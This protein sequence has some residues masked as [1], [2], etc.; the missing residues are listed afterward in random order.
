MMP[1]RWPLPRPQQRN[2]YR[3]VAPVEALSAR[4]FRL[5]IERGYS[6]NDL[7]IAAG[8][9]AGTIKTGQSV[10]VVSGPNGIPHK[11]RV[12]QLHRFAG[13]GRAGAE[14]PPPT[15]TVELVNNEAA[16]ADV[17]HARRQAAA[18]PLTRLRR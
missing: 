16:E 8:I 6:V 11:S 14:C 10:V 1:K 18:R 2:R 5:R 3:R 17:I 12:L 13:L 15:I 7:A 4:I 9:F